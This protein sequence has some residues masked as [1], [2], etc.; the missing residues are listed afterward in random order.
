MLL[1]FKQILCRVNTVY[2]IFLLNL[3]GKPNVI[4]LNGGWTW[5]ATMLNLPP[6][7]ITAHLLV[8]FLEQASFAFYRKYGVNFE[9]L[10][11]FLLEKYLVLIPNSSIAS[12]T[13]LEIVCKEIIASGQNRIK[14]PVGLRLS[15]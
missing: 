4:G 11:R 2:L 12:K 1:L 14:E 15:Q 10:V 3:L 9:K 5:L 8:A 6:R 7:P 13:R